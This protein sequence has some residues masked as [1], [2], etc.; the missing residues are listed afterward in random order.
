M[1]TLIKLFLLTILLLVQAVV[2]AE[3]YPGAIDKSSVDTSQW[4][5]KLC[6]YEKGVSGTVDLGI[7]YVSADSFKFGEYTGL[8]ER[9]GFP[10]ANAVTRFRGEEAA[11]WNLDASNL[12]LDSRSLNAEGGKYGKYKVFLKYEELPRYYS[13]STVTPFLGTGGGSLVLPPGW[14]QAGST[15]G[16]SALPGSLRQVDLDTQRKNLGVGASL[17]PSPEWEYSVNF[18]HDTREGTKR[19]AGTFFFNSAQLVRPVDYETDQLDVTA[20]YTGKKWQT[21]FSYYASV[22]DN[23]RPSLTWQNPYT[24]ASGATAGQLALPPENQFH[25]I[26]ATAGYQFS[27]NTRATA[28]IAFG[29][30]TQNENFLPATLNSTLA[31]YP[32][33]QPRNSLD[34][35]V[36]TVNANLKV[37]SIITNMLRLNAVYSYNDH[38]NKTPQATYNWVTTD[39]FLATPRTNLPYSF[40]RNK[41]KLSADYGSVTQLRSSVGVDYDAYER[42]Y[43]DVARTRENTIWAKFIARKLEN[44]DLT[45]RVAHADRTKSGDETVPGLTPPDNPLMTKYNLASRARNSTGFRAD[46]T[47]S[48]TVNV[49]LGFDYSKDN[50]SKSA[51]GLTSSEDFSVNGD[52]SVMFTKQSSLYFFLSRELIKSRQVGSQ[53]FSTPDWTGENNDM[54]DVFGIGVKHALI[55][56]KLDVGADYTVSN[57]RG[58]VN[59]TTGAPDPAFPDIIARL[60]SLKLYATYRLQDSLSLQGTYW[61]ERYDTQ[62]WMYDDVTPDTIPNVLTLGEQPPTYHVNV[63]ML[64]VRYKF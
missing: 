19:I 31:G 16:M 24:S 38:N 6:P 10:V 1:K 44:L 26:L 64:S 47:A 4:L 3:D 15:G 18:R 20:S 56:D 63:I 55:K 8:K 34:G 48:E 41:L 35:R 21:R 13:D 54:I 37:S 43:Q 23:N 2:S 50:Y 59:V 29:R 5:C 32:F 33:T 27:D 42:T 9:G 62:N 14:V 53:T 39:D 11:Y 25:Q 22:F 12:G 61:Y 51:I 45:F 17:I 57:S 28:D 60:N 52:V 36:D 40:K 49:G 7:G 30:M 58:E 46:I